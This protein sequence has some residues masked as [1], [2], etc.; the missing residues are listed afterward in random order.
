MSGIVS[1]RSVVVLECT[2]EEVH[3]RIN[4]NAGGD[5]TVRSDDSLDMIS[6]K[7]DIFDARTAPLIAYYSKRDAD[8]VTIRTTETSTPENSYEAFSAAYAGLPF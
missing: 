3:K 2:S 1:V 5:R 7:L 4:R 6:R 8:I